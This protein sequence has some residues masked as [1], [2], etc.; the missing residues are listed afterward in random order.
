MI[1]MEI[2]NLLE[3]PK[4]LD[5]GKITKSDHK[6]RFPFTDAANSIRIDTKMNGKCRLQK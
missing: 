2:V 4:I 5:W 3:Q 1:K 6:V